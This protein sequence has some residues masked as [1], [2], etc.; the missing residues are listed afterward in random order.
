MINSNVSFSISFKLHALY[1]KV[2]LPVKL[3]FFLTGTADSFLPEKQK[4]NLLSL[5]EEKKIPTLSKTPTLCHKKI[6]SEIEIKGKV[7]VETFSLF[8]IFKFQRN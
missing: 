8:E 7:F 4:E 5:M 2:N 6:K 1:T 3:I